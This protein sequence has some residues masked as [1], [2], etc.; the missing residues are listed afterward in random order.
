MKIEFSNS[1]RPKMFKDLFTGE[2]F[3]DEGKVLMKCEDDRAV[4]LETGE[5][6]YVGLER[7][8]RYCPNAS[9]TI[10]RRP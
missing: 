5:F 9:L 3:M 2:V 1:T 7:Q 8:V 10:E 4:L 6:R